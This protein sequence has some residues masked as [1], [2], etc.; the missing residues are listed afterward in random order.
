MI[1]TP[2]CATTDAD[3]WLSNNRGERM[4]AADL[5]RRCPVRQQC[6]EDVEQLRTRPIAR[7]PVS[8]DEPTWLPWGVWA[9]LAY[10]GKGNPPTAV[11]EF[12]HGRNRYR[13]GCRCEVCE[14]AGEREKARLQARRAS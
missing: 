14:A 11:P 5:C 7:G 13:A 2:V 10:D 8:A 4:T 12:K 3:L 6:Y 9:G 1:D